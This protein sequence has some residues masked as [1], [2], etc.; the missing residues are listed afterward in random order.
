MKDK[1]TYLY[2]GLTW[3]TLGALVY[4]R[5]QELLQSGWGIFWPFIPFI[6]GLLI[7]V[8]YWR[9]GKKGLILAGAFLA[10]SG[11]FLLLFSAKLLAWPGIGKVWPILSF[12]AG[13]AFFLAYASDYSGFLLPVLALFFIAAGFF[14]LSRNQP[15]VAVQLRLYA[16]VF[17]A[18]AGC[19]LLIILFSQKRRS[20]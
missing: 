17:T 16:Q 18:A 14:G 7:V 2:H 6:F 15:A 3:I 12:S 13:I 9:D 10:G 19:Y 8:D 20:S 5:R 1:K 4:W 11:F